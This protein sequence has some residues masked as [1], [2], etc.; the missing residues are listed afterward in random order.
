MW[1]PQKSKGKETSKIRQKVKEWTLGKGLDLGCGLDKI[2]QD[3]IGIDLVPF[4]GVDFVL[5][6][7]DLYIFKNGEF[8]YIF[9]SHVLEDIEDT[10]DTLREWWR[11]IKLHG[12]LIL[13]LPHKRFYPN[14][15]E[16]GSN[17]AHKHD[18]EPSDIKSILDRICYY[19]LDACEERNQDDEYSF[20]LII[21][22]TGDLKK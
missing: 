6:I 15:G 14:I 7:R 3:A 9:S 22:K 16:E 5:D 11:L 20:L 12:F 13:Y 2:S 10:T 19:K 4:P 18:F 21:R 8:D 1:T 17:P